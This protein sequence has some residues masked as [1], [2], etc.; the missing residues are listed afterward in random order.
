MEA[1]IMEAIEKY[2]LSLFQ[3]SRLEEGTKNRAEEIS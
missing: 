3:N 2:E 1:E